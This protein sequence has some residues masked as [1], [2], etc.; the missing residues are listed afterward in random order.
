MRQHLTR[1][2]QKKK[3]KQEKKEKTSIY[4]IEIKIKQIRTK[5]TRKTVERRRG[6][7]ERAW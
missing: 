7:G 5:H 1:R 4:T 6:E 3:I 2:K